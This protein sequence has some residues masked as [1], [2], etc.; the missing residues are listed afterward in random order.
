MVAVNLYL[1][2]KDSN[3]KKSTKDRVGNE[4]CVGSGLRKSDVIVGSDEL[5]GGYY[6]SPPSKL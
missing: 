1:V 4:M 5:R 2:R 3:A 6:I